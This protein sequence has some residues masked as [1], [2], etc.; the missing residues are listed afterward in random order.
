MQSDSVL[1][2]LRGCALVMQFSISTKPSR[3]KVYRLESS[4]AKV[5][6]LVLLVFAIEAC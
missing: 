6:L 1:L 3:A 2:Q 4:A 5:R